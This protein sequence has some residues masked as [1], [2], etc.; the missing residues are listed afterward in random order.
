MIDV[1][2]EQAKEQSPE[3]HNTFSNQKVGENRMNR[4]KPG[5]RSA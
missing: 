2:D 5:Q 3:I 1:I 4:F